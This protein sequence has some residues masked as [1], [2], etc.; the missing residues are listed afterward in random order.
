MKI[1]INNLTKEELIKYNEL[2]K[3]LKKHRITL[4]INVSYTTL[5]LIGFMYFGQNPDIKKM[6]LSALIGIIGLNFIPYNTQDI[7][8]TKRRILNITEKED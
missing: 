4:G 3:E 1:D 7:L 8:D 6:A 2:L 5:S